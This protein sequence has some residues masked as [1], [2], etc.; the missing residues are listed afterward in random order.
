MP[1]RKKVA[2]KLR[3][4]SDCPIPPVRYAEQFRDLL[5]DAIFKNIEDHDYSE[6]FD[7]LAY[8]I[9]P[10][11]RIDYVDTST[12]TPDTGYNPDGYYCCSNCGELGNTLQEMW[13]TYQA[14]DYQGEP[15]FRYCPYCGARVV[16]DD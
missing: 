9:D 12:N 2:D 6:T 14:N 1:S 11:C 5:Q 13:D 7:R 3:Y 16:Y 10:V 8:L 4:L 15:P